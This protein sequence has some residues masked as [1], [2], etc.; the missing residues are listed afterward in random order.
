MRT[1]AIH[2]SSNS[3]ST[4]HGHSRSHG[5]CKHSTGQTRQ[6]S[7]LSFGSQRP[8]ETWPGSS[9]LACAGATAS[10]CRSS[11]PISPLR[12]GVRSRPFASRAPLQTGHACARAYALCTLTRVRIERYVHVRFFTLIPS[13]SVV[14]WCIISR[15]D[16]CYC[17]LRHS[18][19][20]HR[21]A[22]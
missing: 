19:A 20:I 9:L 18:A 13:N 15:D 22:S 2:G 17:I 6:T 4:S 8:T 11:T 12:C 7:Y 21:T 16:M 3:K 10:V 14:T 1:T 5:S